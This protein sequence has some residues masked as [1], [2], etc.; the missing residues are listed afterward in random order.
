MGHAGVI[1]LFVQKAF[2][3]N[4]VFHYSPCEQSALQLCW[5]GSLQAGGF[6]CSSCHGGFSIVVQHWLL[7]WWF[8]QIQC[9][10]QDYLLGMYVMLFCF[11]I[12]AYWFI[13][14][15][16]LWSIRDLKFFAHA[17]CPVL[18]YP[19]QMIFI[20]WCCWSGLSLTIILC[21]VQISWWFM[22]FF[23]T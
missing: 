9:C 4:W 20:L 22:A 14:G 13:C 3:A 21:K 18:V 10:M 16:W 5:K 23:H 17:S 1:S 8:C 7:S 6:W 15:N 19:L 11:V 12:Q 2:E